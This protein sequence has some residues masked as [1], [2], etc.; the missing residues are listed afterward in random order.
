EYFRPYHELSQ[1][2]TSQRMTGF[3]GGGLDQKRQALTR[4][5]TT[6]LQEL[7]KDFRLVFTFDTL[8]LI[9]YEY[10]DIQTLCEVKDENSSIKS[11]LFHQIPQ[12]TN[13]VT[14]LA[15]RPHRQLQAEMQ[16]RFQAANCTY[17]SFSIDRL[18]K[19]DAREFLQSLAN[20]CAAL[21]NIN[22]TLFEQIYLGSENGRPIY[23]S[24]AADLTAREGQILSELFQNPRTLRQEIATRL[25]N[26]LPEQH[27]DT[28]KYLAYARQGLDIPLLL[29][30]TS[31][32]MSQKRANDLFL[33][34][35]EYTFIKH[36]DSLT[37]P[38][39][40]LFLHDEVFDIIDQ[41]RLRAMD[42][43]TKP[44]FEKLRSYYANLQLTVSYQ[45]EKLQEE[46][47]SHKK[48]ER[49]EKQHELEKIM[50]NRLYYELQIN[51]LQAY[52]R[53]Y[54]RWSEEAIKSHHS[55]F[56]M[57]LQ[58]VVLNFF[59]Y[60]EKSYLWQRENQSLHSRFVA[61]YKTI[62]THEEA[63]K[64]NSALFWVRR[65][66]ARGNNIKAHR[67]AEKIKQDSSLSW[68]E[69][70]DRLCHTALIV[71]Q[72]EVRNS[73][74]EAKNETLE[75][76]QQVSEVLKE[77]ASFQD[78]EKDEQWRYF[79]ILGRTN[80]MIGHT[81]RLESQ[82]STAVTYYQKSIS[83]YRQV[84]VLDEMAATVTNL[85][86][87]YAHLGAIDEAE[88]LAEDAISIW[89]KLGRPYNLA[90]S[91]NAR[92]LIALLADQPHRAKAF[93][94]QA[95]QLFSD[96]TNDS[97]YKSDLRVRGLAQ[98]GLGEAYRRL[99]NLHIQEVY[100]LED[101]MQFYKNSRDNLQ[102]AL[103]IFKD[104]S[105]RDTMHSLAELGR[106][107]RDWAIAL[108][109]AGRIQDAVER[110]YQAEDFLKKARKM[111][112]EKEA[113]YLIA[114]LSQDLM[115]LY[116]ETNQKERAGQEFNRAMDL[117]N[118]TYLPVEN[119]GF[120][121]IEQ[122]VDANWQVLGKIFMLR[123][124][125]ALAYAPP[126]EE[127]WHEAVR[128]SYIE[129]GILYFVQAVACFT[130]YSTALPFSQNPKM[131]L[132][133]TTIYHHFKSYKASRLLKVVGYAGQTAVQYQVAKQLDDLIQYMKRT[134]G[135]Y[136]QL[137]N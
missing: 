6:C 127:T 66:A 118:P 5:F 96:L 19:P 100:T 97:G 35:R 27:S 64:R 32:S 130:Q 90:L 70:N 81:H 69:A 52:W 31:G 108:Y 45:L 80:H 17:H 71:I 95:D 134:L 113:S 60:V 12:L 104:S 11:W 8:E 91:L 34:M 14:V 106:L 76:L 133:K 136:I 2:F 103:T 75:L 3:G 50:A 79:R 65:Y 132:T 48:R 63:F 38:A 37:H 41:E 137:R 61:L 23:L 44:I 99:G 53:Y 1:Q 36:A 15:G 20:K 77:P 85:S 78:M 13:S 123:A 114:D 72:S 28:I 107:Y 47:D 87:V 105:E 29:Y 49:E 110:Q 57:Q 131:K 39:G 84:D 62:A 10:E 98:L 88:A 121:Q 9:Q 128:M 117:I 94:T 7:S 102:T 22:D 26:D 24:L 30:L 54:N 89:R 119:G 135:A 74:G 43:E 18:T 73:M 125:M 115:A 51:P 112:E 55:S 4:Q 109:K 92:G 40:Q 116:W 46:A 82:F 16:E 58:D 120:A 56:D 126:L 122:P 67:V 59:R 111:A 86:Y 93:C 101:A 83:L 21:A 124:K 33:E 42:E 25:L 68:A 129:E